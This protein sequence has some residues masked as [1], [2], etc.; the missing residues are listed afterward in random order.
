[1]V[2]WFNHERF[3]LQNDYKHDYIVQND[4]MI[5]H[6]IQILTSVH[7]RWKILLTIIKILFEIFQL[8]SFLSNVIFVK[9]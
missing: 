1:M 2:M 9:D 6:K 5:I 8:M 4:L 3:L 7:L